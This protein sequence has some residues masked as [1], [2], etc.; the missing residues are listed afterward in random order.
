MMTGT[1]KKP[2]LFPPATE[3]ASGF[4]SDNRRIVITVCHLLVRGWYTWNTGGASEQG[5]MGVAIDTRRCC[6]GVCEG[7]W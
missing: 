1:E 5:G 3:G 6:S 7:R 4:L 2:A